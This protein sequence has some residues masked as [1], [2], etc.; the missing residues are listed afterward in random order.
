MNKKAQKGGI[1]YNIFKCYLRFLH[2][3]IFYRKTYK[4]NAENIPSNT[5]PTII[6]SNP[7]LFERPSRSIIYI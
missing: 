5:T 3:K 4:I 7:K 2:D 1:A 6:V